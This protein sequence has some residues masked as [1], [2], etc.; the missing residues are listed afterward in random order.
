MILKKEKG[1][2]NQAKEQLENAFEATERSITLVNEM[3]DVSRIEG[4]R[5]ELNLE[6]LNLTKLVADFVENTKIQAESKQIKLTLSSDGNVDYFV[7]ADK[8]KVLQI[9]NNLLNNAIKFTPQKGS[10]AISL[11]KTG[12]KI[13]TIITDTGIG[14][15]EGDFPKLFVK[16]GRLDTSLSSVS[17]KPGTG[18]G[19][20]IS[21]KLIELSG[22]E[23]KVK[24]KTN[25]GSA[26]TFTLPEA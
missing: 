11:K 15:K 19:L 20:Y 5:L 22:G 7:K 9:L 10:V 6:K 18:L 16:F 21:K 4:G 17:E 23:I 1:L 3:L 24:S 12:N 8:D 13:E 2:T 14:I 25:K 26:F